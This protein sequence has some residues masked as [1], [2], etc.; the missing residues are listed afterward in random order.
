MRLS[1]LP[2]ANLKLQGFL[3]Y[4]TNKD[5]SQKTAYT[6]QKK[7]KLQKEGIFSSSIYLPLSPRDISLMKKLEIK[8][9]ETTYYSTFK[10]IK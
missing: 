9:T 7:A 6:H 3:P 10:S 8:E 4:Q 1:F 5:R 2:N